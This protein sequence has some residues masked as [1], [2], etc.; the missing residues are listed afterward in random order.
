MFNRTPRAEKSTLSEQIP[1]MPVLDAQM[2]MGHQGV[3]LIASRV[4][5]KENEKWVV[6]ITDLVGEFFF[7][8][9]SFAFKLFFYYKQL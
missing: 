3:P 6:I 2:L 5:R 9:V 4:V 1:N 7:P 8:Q